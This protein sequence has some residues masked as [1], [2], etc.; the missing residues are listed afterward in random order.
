MATAGVLVGGTAGV[1]TLGLV[2]I[3]A[4]G[5]LIGGSASPVLGYSATATAAITVGAHA[6][7][8]STGTVQRWLRTTYAA[9]LLDADGDPD[10]VD[11]DRTVSLGSD[12]DRDKTIL[13]DP[14]S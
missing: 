1:P 9:A 13:I 8:S 12:T 7:P 14:Y 5:I 3:P 2:A 4:A 11:P 10:A 6:I